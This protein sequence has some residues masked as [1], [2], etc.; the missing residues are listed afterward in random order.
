MNTT[1]VHEFLGHFL[2]FPFRFS[3]QA[4]TPFAH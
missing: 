3:A 2:A 1:Y 4:L